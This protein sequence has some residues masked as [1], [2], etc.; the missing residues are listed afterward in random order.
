VQIRVIVGQSKASALFF[1]RFFPSITV[2]EK[3]LALAESSHYAL[4]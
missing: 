3:K 2:H 1:R 4:Y